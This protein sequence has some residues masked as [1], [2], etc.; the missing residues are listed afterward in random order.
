MKKGLLIVL[1]V[2][3]IAV[4]TLSMAGKSEGQYVLVAS[5]QLGDQELAVTSGHGWG[6]HAVVTEQG[7]RQ[8]ATNGGENTVATSISSDS[9]SRFSNKSCA[10]SNNNYNSNGYYNVDNVILS[11][12]NVRAATTSR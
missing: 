4:P 12:G 9:D 3:L 1:I 11:N 6:P 2:G 8:A 10:N 5:N 7:G